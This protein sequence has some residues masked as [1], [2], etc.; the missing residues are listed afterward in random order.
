MVSFFTPW[1]KPFEQEVPAET[2]FVSIK[3][4]SVFMKT[5]CSKAPPK[6]HVLAY[7]SVFYIYGNNGVSFAKSSIE[8]PL[9]MITCN[10]VSRSCSES[11]GN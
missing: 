8:M 10:G 5:V 6:F 11:N 9:C 3:T 4:F 2:V 1:G 7:I